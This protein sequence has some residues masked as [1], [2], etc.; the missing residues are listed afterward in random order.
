MIWYILGV[1]VI[2]TGIIFVTVSAYKVWNPMLGIF[3]W[4]L[5]ML[6]GLYL[7]FT[8]SRQEYQ[9]EEA[10]KNYFRS[11]TMLNI[12]DYQT[13]GAVLIQCIANDATIVLNLLTTNVRGE[14][15]LLHF[16]EA[17][18]QYEEINIYTYKKWYPYECETKK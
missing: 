15:E 7:L 5:S 9:A 4:I 10:A 18:A 8:P 17:T 13:G 3:I 12:I 1:V 16:D 2:L 14:E 11:T 6:S